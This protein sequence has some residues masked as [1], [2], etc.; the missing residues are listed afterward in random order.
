M[1]AKTACGMFR[2]GPRDRLASHLH[3]PGK[4]R[5]WGMR[6]AREQPEGVGGVEGPDSSRQRWQ[7]KIKMLLCQG[8]TPKMTSNKTVTRI[9]S[10][11]YLQF[12]LL[13]ALHRTTKSQ[14]GRDV[15][16]TKG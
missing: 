1:G 11:T 15:I 5:P 13:F 8:D 12:I 9:F 2:P 14:L 7:E 4:E 6:E 16:L 10:G 3:Q